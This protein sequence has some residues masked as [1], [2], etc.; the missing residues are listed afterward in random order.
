MNSSAAKNKSQPGYHHVQEERRR[1]GVADKKNE[2]FS[3]LVS[4]KGVALDRDEDE[5]MTQVFSCFG[6]RL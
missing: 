2:N 3:G 6:F 1:Y 5:K 4:V